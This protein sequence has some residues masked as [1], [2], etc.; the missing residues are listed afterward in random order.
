MKLINCAV[1]NARILA[2]KYQCLADNFEEREWTFA[3]ITETWLVDGPVYETVKDDLNLGRGIGLL[4]QNRKASNGRNTGG[5]VAVAYKN[6]KI[7][8]KSYPFK[9]SRCEIVIAKAKIPEISRPIFI[10]GVYMPPNMC[11][12]VLD[13]Y[14]DT[15]YN[16]V[17]KIKTDERDPAVFNGGDFNRYDVSDARGISRTLSVYPHQQLEAARDWTS[18]S[19]T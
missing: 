6:G 2:S 12:P 11:R 15:L 14:L 9:K 5:G 7:S 4:C 19:Q 3:I 10:I 8:V 16:A 17:S 13:R 18:F 1:I